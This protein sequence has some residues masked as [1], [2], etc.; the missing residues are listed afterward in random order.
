[1]GLAGRGALAQPT[2]YDGLDS[3]VYTF[4]RYALA[5]ALLRGGACWG[6]DVLLNILVRL[7]LLSGDLVDHATH[8]GRPLSGGWANHV[9]ANEAWT[10]ERKAPGLPAP[11]ETRGYLAALDLALKSVES[12]SHESLQERVR[13]EGGG[14]EPVAWQMARKPNTLFRN[15]PNFRATGWSYFRVFSSLQSSRHCGLFFGLRSAGLS[16]NMAGL[17]KTLP[18]P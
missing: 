8:H 18:S 5:S 16:G 17:S 13:P 12:A 3:F 7:A 2:T 6:A 14:L 15:S 10:A 1:L 4:L 11:P 9:I